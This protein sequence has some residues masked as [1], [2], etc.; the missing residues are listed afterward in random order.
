ML[1]QPLLVQNVIMTPQDVQLPSGAAP[2]SY[3]VD[4]HTDV[5]HQEK[6]LAVLLGPQR[7]RLFICAQVMSATIGAATLLVDALYPACAYS[8][9]TLGVLA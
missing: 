1:Y 3:M 8:S 7:L 5:R 6:E 4:I 2:Q 9:F